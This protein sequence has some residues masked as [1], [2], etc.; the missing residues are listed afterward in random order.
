M[1][2]FCT[3][4]FSSD[5]N[6]ELVIRELP[7]D[8]R[9]YVLYLPPEKILSVGC[10]K[11]KLDYFLDDILNVSIVSEIVDSFS[12]GSRLTRTFIKD[13]LQKIYKNN[14]YNKTPKAT[15][16]EEYFDLKDCQII[17]G[18]KKTRGYLILKKKEL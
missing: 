5:K 12:V 16:L 7:E 13:K 9:N 6:R 15:D 18:G 1:K 3:T 8:Y 10:Q 2:L 17:V 4:K 14:N 11:S